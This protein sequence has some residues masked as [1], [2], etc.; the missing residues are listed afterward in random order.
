MSLSLFY[1]V[2]QGMNVTKDLG[3]GKEKSVDFIIRKIDSNLDIINI[4]LELRENGI[5]KYFNLSE[6]CAYKILPR[7]NLYLPKNPLKIKESKEESVLI[8]LKAQKSVEFGLR[9]MYD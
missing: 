1:R 7:C 9:K 5:S 2:N 8:E 4:E 3:K 6:R